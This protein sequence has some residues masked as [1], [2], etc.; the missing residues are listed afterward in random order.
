MKRAFNILG[1][2]KKIDWTNIKANNNIF[3]VSKSEN[4]VESIDPSQVDIESIYML[5]KVQKRRQ[6]TQSRRRKKW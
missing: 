5:Q 4:I 6:Q 2:N 3:V 1:L